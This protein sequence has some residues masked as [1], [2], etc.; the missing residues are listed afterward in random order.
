[1]T[2]AGLYAFFEYQIRKRRIRERIRLSIFTWLASKES[3]QLQLNDESDLQHISN[4]HN[5]DD[6]VNPTINYSSHN[7]LDSSSFFP[8]SFQNIRSTYLLTN[9]T[10]SENTS[11]D[12]HK[13]KN[14]ATLK[15]LISPRS[16]FAMTS[17][18][19]VVI[20]TIPNKCQMSQR[21]AKGAE[22]Y[23]VLQGNGFLYKK[24]KNILSKKN[25]DD[26]DNGN[27]CVQIKSGDT[28]IVNPW[29]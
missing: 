14:D 28:F 8:T 6:V 17:S 13:I 24:K 25:V 3:Q 18:L 23:Y 4:I 12:F 22:L 9:P 20:L 27:V 7:I 10:L 16:G 5:E 15:V 21:E 29:R 26:R 2:G 11:N 19:Y 1:M